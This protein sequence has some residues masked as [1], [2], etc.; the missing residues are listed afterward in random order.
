MAVTIAVTADISQASQAVSQVS[1][2]L[3]AAFKGVQDQMK[4]MES[5]SGQ[6]TAKMVT[7][8][9]QLSQ[10]T[11]RLVAPQQDLSRV[12]LQTGKAAE[13]QL[14]QFEK[15]R[16]QY[17]KTQ[18]ASK[19]VVSS[20]G[21]L[22]TSFKGLA[23]VAGISFS[24]QG[25][26][27]LTTSIVEAGIA[28]DRLML[29]LKGALGTAQAAGEAYAFVEAVANRLGIGL[30]TAVEGFAKLSAATQ[31]T[32]V[33]GQQTRD[34][35]VSLAEASRVMG[36]TTAETGGVVTA[37]TQI[38]GKNTVSMEELR[39]QLGERLPQVLRLTAK[40]MG[41]TTS[42][43]IEMVSKGQVLAQDFIPA[44]T[45]AFQQMGREAPAAAQ[46]VQAALE[47][48]GNAWL[49]LKVTI[50]QSGLLELVARISEEMTRVI[51]QTTNWINRTKRIA[52]EMG[53][54]PMVGEMQ[55]ITQEI[56]TWQELLQK[57]GPNIFGPT[58]M[59]AK[60]AITALE[61]QRDA[62]AA[63]ISVK[64]RVVEVE[65]AARKAADATTE[66]E[67][68]AQAAQDKR[69]TTLR[70][71]SKAYTG[72]EDDIKAVVVQLEALRS[73]DVPSLQAMQIDP[74]APD[75]EKRFRERETAL[76]KQHQELINKRAGLDKG[77]AASAIR[78]AGQSA[79][80]IARAAEEALAIQLKNEETLLKQSM[81]ERRRII[82]EA[83]LQALQEQG[84]S[85]AR[86]IAAQRIKDIREVASAEAE[87]LETLKM[88]SLTQQAEL[89]TISLNA[90]IEA[91]G[92]NL[93]AATKAQEELR[94]LD[95]VTEAE[96]AKIRAERLAADQ[97]VSEQSVAD[98]L[99]AAQRLNTQMKEIEADRIQSRITL[100]D[101]QIALVQA[102][103][104][105]EVLTEAEGI[106]QIQALQDSRLEM[107]RELYRQEAEAAL[108]RIDAEVAATDIGK[109]EIAKI[110]E[111]LAQ[112]LAQLDVQRQ[113]QQQ[114][115][116]NE[117]SRG[118]RDWV[119]DVRGALG[120]FLFRW[121][122]GQ[123]ISMKDVLNDLKSYFFRIIADMV[124]KA[125]TSAI[126]I[127]IV[128]AVVGGMGGGGV[129]GTIG[130]VLGVAG[131]AAGVGDAGGGAG[132]T[133]GGL[134]ES[135]GTALTGLGLA[136]NLY[137][138]LGL[139]TLTNYIGSGLTGLKDTLMTG[140][141]NLF[142]SSAT[143]ASQQA[144]MESALVEQGAGITPAGQTAAFGGNVLALAGGLA[145]IG[146][147]I[148]GALNAAN[149]ASKAA[150]AA[151]AAAGAATAAVAA[152]G[153]ITGAAV[154]T[155]AGTGWT[156]IG[157]IVAAVL[158]VIGTVLDR[159]IK[160]E[161]PT[162]AVGAPGGLG[163][164]A[165]GGRL[166]V[167]G[168]LGS[169]VFREEG[170]DK[171]FASGIQAQ[172][173]AGI[174]TAVTAAVQTI[175]AVAL[176]PAAL[177]EPTQAALTRTLASIS[178]IN[179]SN[180]K[181]M[182]RD[183]TEQLRF[184][185]IQVVAG[186]LDPINKAFDQLRDDATL[187]EQVE[188]LSGT[189]S[190][191]VAIFKNLQVELDEIG[192]SENADVLRQLSGVR[193]QVEN[194]GRRIAGSA[195]QIA[196]GIVTGIIDQFEAIAPPTVGAES[197]ASTTGAVEDL[198][199][200]LAEQI[201][202]LNTQMTTAFEALAVLRSTKT[203]LEQ[204]GLPGGGVGEQADRLTMAMSEQSGRIA[205][206]IVT[207]AL[208][209]LSADLDQV[210]VQPI[211]IQ[212]TTV[213][214]LF[215]DSMAALQALWLEWHRL[216]EVGVDATAIRGQFE[217]VLGG[218]LEGTFTVL[219]DA[220][221]TGSITEFLGILGSIPD[222]V[223]KLNPELER[224]RERG[225]AFA[226]VA[227]PVAQG[228]AGFEEAL[229]TTGDRVNQSALRMAELRSAIADAGDA[230]DQALPLYAQ[231]GQAI[232]A[233]AQAQIA[234]VQAIGAVIAQTEEILLQRQ[235]PVAQFRA[236]SADIARV[237]TPTIMGQT[238]SGAPVTA[239]MTIE[240]MGEL[241]T[242]YA[243]QLSLLDAL[244]Q[245]IEST[246]ESIDQTLAAQGDST[247]QLNR[248]IAEVLAV[249]N[250]IRATGATPDNLTDLAGLL[251]NLLS[252]V[253][254][255]IQTVEGGIESVH[256]TLR[257]QL[258]VAEQAAAVQGE[259][260]GIFQTI[261][262][263]GQPTPDELV[264]LVGLT[265]EA[266]SLQAQISQSLRGSLDSIHATLM[267]QKSPAEQVAALQ[268]E[269][270]ALMRT[271]ADLNRATPEQLAALVDLTT[272][273][274][275]LQRQISQ[276]LESTLADL[277]D[278]LRTEVSPAEQLGA[279]RRDIGAL[280]AIVA[281][282]TATPDQLQRL[283]DLNQEL[284]GVGRQNDLMVV[285]KEALD[286]LKMLAPTVQAQLV[287]SQSMEQQL[288]G[289]LIGLEGI[290]QAQLTASRAMEAQLSSLLWQLGVSLNAQLVQ[291]QTI[292][293]AVLNEL[294][295]VQGLLEG[296]LVEVTSLEAQTVNALT[297]QLAYLDAQ[298]IAQ[299]GTNNIQ[300]IIRGIQEHALAE[301]Q[302]INH[303]LFALFQQ[304]EGVAALLAPR[305]A[306]VAAQSGGFI[307]SHAS[308]N[309]TMTGPLALAQ[310]GM[311]P[312]RLEPG[313]R[314][315]PGPFTPA[316]QGALVAVN[317]AFPR[318]AGGGFTVPGQGS[319]DTFPALVPSGA[320]VLN[321]RAAG[322]L[323]FQAGG[324]VP[325]STR[326]RSQQGIT[327]LHF[328]FRGARFTRG[329]EDAKEI[330][331]ILEDWNR[332]RG[333]SRL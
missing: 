1:S 76:L 92:K 129:L 307:T 234:Q 235:G 164:T 326:E 69:L 112:Q 140:L 187:Q 248:Q 36:L 97:N 264:E 238:S 223:I 60:N 195:G 57:E 136:K 17:L 281:A 296:M 19:G 199:Q 168:D 328:D 130:Q 34:L 249:E 143:T 206:Q 198:D 49:T 40:E 105:G 79:V 226:A 42:T 50:A 246:L 305:V 162:V 68:K 260:A 75:F 145:A 156:G 147:G 225:A 8:L 272:Q 151:S 38:I 194:F 180:A 39:Q 150:F 152:Y 29:S 148:Y 229:S 146:A 219:R 85:A 220:F 78:E 273:A 98:Q 176:D 203:T 63:Q 25:L 232:M 125:A 254:A 269:Q 139:D 267:D 55:R 138:M 167:S 67:I 93:S 258:S 73:M 144:L 280:E 329:Q 261:G 197:I 208:A 218:V 200:S 245:T 101:E 166:G 52:G 289:Q 2:N 179:S 126:V 65:D 222:A 82:D 276:S 45:R 243:K 298:L 58:E 230:A 257:S 135:G 173:E 5:A 306:P 283:V 46:S 277:R 165:E 104:D 137:S 188:R 331:R 290:A 163:I 315:M 120:D 233:N 302:H 83:A 15:L 275:S 313:E 87:A 312:V 202:N 128:S 16:Q 48:L 317:Q 30:Q 37:L 56:Q 252:S 103:V 117:L 172:M 304:Q 155:A 99:K 70:D 327:H 191:L 119:K 7:G 279:L 185:N 51:N 189:T 259:I 215:T 251:Q 186:M 64:Q 116:L 95:K 107:T 322:T 182:E 210:L 20:V 295:L 224:L 72:L 240:D 332:R 111:T 178:T 11:I 14:N 266:L 299:Y 207:R 303:L 183:I 80:E 24:V 43:F 18:D 96:R 247:T 100:V 171:G 294:V 241:T 270:V 284:L 196:E 288:V 285:E 228:I 71:A 333:D 154:V 221:A 27:G 174:T 214:G 237:Q 324:S 106:K 33:Q 213:Q 244:R 268:A 170:V 308:I 184:V 21:S 310:G 74:F 325:P 330:I 47:R 26:V 118:W 31:G 124:A 177:L 314:V 22:L 121:M 192:T 131:A 90:E 157:L 53:L 217:R 23:A 88:N 236:V 54:A 231:L 292:E 311:V 271:M 84:P 110:H 91:S 211:A 134:L 250:D 286:N 77:A 212:A 161:G 201:T 153:A 297:Q 323:G 6:A 61:A 94:N 28:N 159:V 242:L 316:Q 301:L 122:D 32:V 132:G 44:V 142:Q 114:E 115:H 321:R 169:R 35:F 123:V 41:F 256:Q 282:G 10:S 4:A 319:G 86:D 59:Q 291:M 262:Q 227:G 66:A 300:D 253:Q 205:T 13:T 158:A 89:R 309:R 81:D 239:P 193:N 278:T 160:P 12:I 127:P 263:R 62:L 141:Q 320:F 175:N 149:T 3:S 293:Q 274:L 209:D 113:T 255:L 204:A 287:A 109:A 9:Q 216:E 102:R 190:G 265:Q 133:G 318:F 108:A 181:K